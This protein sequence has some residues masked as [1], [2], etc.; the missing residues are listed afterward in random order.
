VG[1]PFESEEATRPR[2]DFRL[3]GVLQWVVVAF[4]L[5]RWTR[6]LWGWWL[7]GP[8]I[9]IHHVT[10]WLVGLPVW[11]PL[12]SVA[13]LL[14]HLVALLAVGR[15]LATLAREVT[16]WLR[17]PRRASQARVDERGLHAGDHLLV[18]R[19]DVASVEVSTDADAGFALVVGTRDGSTLRIP[20]RSESSARA[21][22][23]A[24]DGRQRESL[25]FEGVSSGRR[26]QTRDVITALL[27]LVALS[28][29]A[30]LL[31]YG[32]ATPAGWNL[33][34][35]HG[36]EEEIPY[37]FA[38]WLG[39]LHSSGL[40]AVGAALS[41]WSA[42]GAIARRL[43]P[44]RVRVGPHDVQAGERTVAAAEIA[45]VETG[46]ASDVTLAL[47]DGKRVRLTFGA[48]R[49]L[50]ERD[51]FVARVRAMAGEAQVETYPAAETSGVRVALRADPAVTPD[52]A[53]ASDED[54]E[55]EPQAPRARRR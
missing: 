35:I 34:H 36:Y 28:A 54:A 22:A 21:L 10:A 43:R 14:V 2:R 5:E 41:T 44:G 11:D 26:R 38:W 50:V 20:Q 23:A 17:V 51:L 47:R 1:A 37:T 32:L 25:V 39:Q 4:A 9:A 16:G 29:L 30:G 27:R 13:S 15:A 31:A 19:R 55:A 12:Q 24:L 8:L 53:A 7:Q 45:A 42:I 3:L 52:D 46:D 6:P 33:L 40:L 18:S 49:S 48:E